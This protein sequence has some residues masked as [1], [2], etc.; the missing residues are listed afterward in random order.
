MNQIDERINELLEKVKNHLMATYGDKIKKVILYGSH[1]RG[2]PTKDSDIDVLVF[3]DRSIEPSEVR[4]RMS[5][6]I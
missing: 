1:A 5:D 2:T 4:G 6:S 3:V